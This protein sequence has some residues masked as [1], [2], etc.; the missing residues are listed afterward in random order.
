MKRGKLLDW[1]CNHPEWDDGDLDE[2]GRYRGRKNG[3]NE[4][5]F[6]ITITLY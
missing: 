4:D 3:H 5:V 1:Y 6:I 2:G